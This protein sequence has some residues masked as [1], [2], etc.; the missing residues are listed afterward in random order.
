[1]RRWVDDDEP[2]ECDV[3]GREFD[4]WDLVDTA[5]GLLCD[6]CQRRGPRR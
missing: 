6:D 3:C 1:M 4:R 2:V 5:M